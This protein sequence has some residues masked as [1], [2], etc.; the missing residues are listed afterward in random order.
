MARKEGAVKHLFAV[1]AVFFLVPLLPAQEKVVVLPPIAASR[2]PTPPPQELKKIL[3]EFRNHYREELRDLLASDQPADMWWVVTMLMPE[4]E[5]HKG[6]CIVIAAAKEEK[7]ARAITITKVPI[8]A[9]KAAFD[10][11]AEAKK[12]A[13]KTIL[14]FNSP[15]RASR[16]GHFIFDVENSV[17]IHFLL[18]GIIISYDL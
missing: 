3:I 1:V 15:R 5:K 7:G 17:L 13:E 4:C 6:W 14:L 16:S 18:S 8:P 10:S 2:T 11:A 9:D 12:A